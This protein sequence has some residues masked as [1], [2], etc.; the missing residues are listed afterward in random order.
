[1]RLH[2][3]ERRALDAG[4]RSDSARQKAL[5]TKG[6]SERAAPPP[7]PP[8]VC[9]CLNC[10]LWPAFTPTCGNLAAGF[11]PSP[12]ECVCEREKEESFENPNKL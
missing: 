12:K 10:E 8:P 2:K 1:M 5:F 4:R 7:P 9:L 11:W 6:K 3:Y